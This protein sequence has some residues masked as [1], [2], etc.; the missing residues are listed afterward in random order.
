MSKSRGSDQTSQEYGS[1]KNADTSPE[2]GRESI[3]SRDPAGSIQDT[4]PRNPGG[5]HNKHNEEE[6]R[7]NDEEARLRQPT[8]QDGSHGRSTGNLGTQGKGKAK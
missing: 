8:T 3:E 4:K 7:K 2:A 5:V 6:H 1:D